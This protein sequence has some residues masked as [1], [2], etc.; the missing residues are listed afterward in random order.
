M[1]EGL[2][3]ELAV[4]RLPNQ[5]DRDR[6][7][8]GHVKVSMPANPL[9]PKG[10]TRRRHPKM[11]P[12]GARSEL[13]RVVN[14]ARDGMVVIWLADTSMRIG[15]LCGLHLVDLHL[16]DDAACGECGPPHVHVCHRWG[17]SNRAA[18]KGKPDWELADGIISGGEIFRASPA[19]IS[20][21][22][23]Y[24]TTEYA[25]YAAGHG[26][27]MIQLAGPRRGEPW[28]T[29][30]ARG[31]LRRAGRRAGLSGRIKPHGFRHT[32]TARVMDASGNDSMV[33]KVVGNWAS[34]RMVDE[35]YGHPDLH[36]PKFQAAL[37][38]VWGEQE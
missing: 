7:L 17:N 11:L 9:A 25:Q 27:L 21:Y 29:D 6:S 4:S 22:F 1:N 18:A 26:M 12:D 24:M 10:G 30:A 2:C 23:T 16:R 5:M 19:M 35:V 34:T 36:S 31:V 28:T 8:L 33:A 20:S 32:A 37:T 13:Q 15:A 38:A 14:T 3:A